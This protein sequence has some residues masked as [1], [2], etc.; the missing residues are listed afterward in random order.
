MFFC[1][2]LSGSYPPGCGSEG[3]S[4]V[5]SATL[6][7]HQCSRNFC[8]KSKNIFFFIIEK[9]ASFSCLTVAI[10]T[11][12]DGSIM[13]T[14]LRRQIHV[15]I[16][17]SQDCMNYSKFDSWN[18]HLKILLAT[19]LHTGKSEKTTLFLIVLGRGG[20]VEPCDTK[21]SEHCLCSQHYNTI[22]VRFCVIMNKKCLNFQKK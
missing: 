12:K 14:M 10:S 1:F 3:T 7:Q 20:Q 15:F 22:P 8:R 21:I 19:K 5:G 4:G 13:H 11:L 16:L 9:C 18:I 17:L 2:S 6:L